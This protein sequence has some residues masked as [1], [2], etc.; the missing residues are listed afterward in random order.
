[1][2][3]LLLDTCILID[4]LRD[5]QEADAFITGLSQ[6]PFLSAMTVAELYAGVREGEERELLDGALDLF[7]V[8]PV[9]EEIAKKGGLYRRTYHGSHGVGLIDAVIATTAEYLGA[10]LITLNKKHFPMLSRLIVPY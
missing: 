6:T 8:I 10:D 7:H 9:S 5:K 3:K 2:E 1:M 4:Y